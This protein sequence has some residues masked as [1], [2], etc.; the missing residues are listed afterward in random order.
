MNFPEH[1][2]IYELIQ[3][4]RWFPC[5]VLPTT[6]ICFP[7]EDVARRPSSYYGFLFCNNYA[8]YKEEAGILK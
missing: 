2:F 5:P 6:K 7:M 1:E 4:G 3:V 8:K